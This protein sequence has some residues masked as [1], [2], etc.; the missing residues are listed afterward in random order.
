M[1]YLESSLTGDE[2]LL[3]KFGTH[4]F[5]WVG[6]GFLSCIVVGIPSLLGLIGLE[7]GLTSRRVLVK[8]GIIS[9]KTEEIMLSAVET[10]R[11]KQGVVGRLLG[12]G[13]V[14]LTGRGMADVVIEVT[15]NPM[16]VKKLVE[17][18]ISNL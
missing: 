14:Y 2:K 11:I 12:Y 3:G 5:F 16:K 18:Q 6:V 13:S 10:V 1:G 9:R 17:Q 7:Q 4:W 15:P 8:K